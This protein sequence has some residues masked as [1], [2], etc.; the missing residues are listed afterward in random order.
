MILIGKGRK[1]SKNNRKNNLR[2][3]LGTVVKGGE[4][5]GVENG[6][7]GFPEKLQLLSKKVKWQS[8]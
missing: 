5:L 3:I 2:A 8:C 7:S 4:L 6:L 1:Y